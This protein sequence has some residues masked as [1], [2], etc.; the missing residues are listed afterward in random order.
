MWRGGIWEESPKRVL[1]VCL[2]GFL[3]AEP[4]DSNAPCLEEAVACQVPL[5]RG[6]RFVYGTINFQDDSGPGAVEVHD[7]PTYDDLPPEL[8]PKAPPV[9]QDL[10]HLS[11]G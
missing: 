11:L 7:H 9:A 10:P 8:E 6:P 1:D 4:D 2:I 3:I 5:F